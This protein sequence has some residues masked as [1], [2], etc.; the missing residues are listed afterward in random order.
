MHLKDA[1]RYRMKTCSGGRHWT[2]EVIELPQTHLSS[3]IFSHGNQR[4]TNHSEGLVCIVVLFCI[5][6][7]SAVVEHALD[8][9]HVASASEGA[10]LQQDLGL[11]GNR[12]WDSF[13]KFDLRIRRVLLPCDSLVS[14]RPAMC[15]S[16]DQPRYR[17]ANPRAMNRAH[18]SLRS[19]ASR[20]IK[21]CKMVLAISP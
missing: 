14:P 7:L 12:M 11:L 21:D 15:E 18:L 9:E 13:E 17:S 4:Y 3:D 1:N 10:H 6:M 19:L 2:H 16:P 8:L 5:K 20:S